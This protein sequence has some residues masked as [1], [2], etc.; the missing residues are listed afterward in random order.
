M[1]LYSSFL[2][3]CWLIND[4]AQGERSVIDVEHIQS[5][6]HTRAATLA[7]AERWMFD[8]CRTIQSALTPFFENGQVANEDKNLS[9][10]V[11]QENN[12]SLKE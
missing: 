4:P 5:G 2:I 8:A 1:K 11:P 9:T 7:E 6:G 12:Q 3:R 10:S